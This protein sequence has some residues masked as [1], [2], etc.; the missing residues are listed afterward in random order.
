M[1]QSLGIEQ[2][3]ATHLA[4][5]LSGA[6]K[7]CRGGR[8]LKMELIV[9]LFF[10][11]GDGVFL[12]SSGC[13]WNSCCRSGCPPTQELR[14]LPVSTSQ[15]LILKVFTTTALLQSRTLSRFGGLEFRYS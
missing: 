4:V 6:V 1:V 5:E 3:G 14:D 11:F 2:V 12:C 7:R 8:A 13:H 15:A 10:F 9:F